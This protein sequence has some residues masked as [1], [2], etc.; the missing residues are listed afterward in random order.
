MPR[1][2]IARNS[3]T[4]VHKVICWWLRKCAA[5]AISFD[6]HCSTVSEAERRYLEKFLVFAERF[7]TLLQLAEKC[8][9]KWCGMAPGSSDAAIALI[10][11]VAFLEW[12]GFPLYS[13]S[14]KRC[15]KNSSPIW[16]S[17]RRCFISSH[18]PTVV[19]SWFDSSGRSARTVRGH[20]T[21]PPRCL[22]DA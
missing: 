10:D 8:S 6:D 9:T 13:S 14:R 19:S 20:M 18:F 11:T 1:G 17:T 16:D 4:D 3:S 15:S 21:F 7:A 5:D 22:Q 12:I 2:V